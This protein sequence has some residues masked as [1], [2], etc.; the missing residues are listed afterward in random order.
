MNFDLNQS[1]NASRDAAN[2]NRE[3]SVYRGGKVA[4][5]KPEVF[6][7]SM[8][9]NEWIESLKAYLAMTNPTAATNQVLIAQ[10]KSF[11]SSTA[12]KRVKH[13]FKNEVCDWC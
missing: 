12:L 2:E 10:V 5:R 11:L 4:A 6:I 7:E 13:I 9:I 3:E 8:N 1:Q